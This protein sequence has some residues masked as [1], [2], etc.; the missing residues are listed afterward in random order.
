[1]DRYSLMLKEGFDAM[2]EDGA[3]NGLRPGVHVYEQYLRLAGD[4]EVAV[5][6]GHAHLLVETEDGF[7]DGLAA[8]DVLGEAF[9]LSRN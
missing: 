2:Y 8:V 4:H 7:R 9:P 5:G 6:G 1:M 3:A